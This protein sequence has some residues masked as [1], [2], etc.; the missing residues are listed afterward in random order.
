MESAAESAPVRRSLLGRIGRGAIGWVPTILLAALVYMVLTTFAVQTVEVQQTS[1]YPTLKP[2]D[3][4]IVEKLDRNFHYGDIVIFAPPSTVSTLAGVD[5]IKRVIGLP[6]DVI[7]IHDGAVWRNDVKLSEPYLVP[8]VTTAP[9]PVTPS[10]MWTLQPGQVFV[11]GD[12]R[13]GSS[14][15]RAFGP[16]NESAVVGR[17]VLRYWPFTKFGMP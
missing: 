8:G 13:P 14:D 16:V 10:E 15:S 12:N 2:G 9:S 11:M 3:R 17:V 5:F 6:G 1:M 7:S 4:L